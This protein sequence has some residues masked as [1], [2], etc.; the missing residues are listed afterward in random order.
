[1]DGPRKLGKTQKQDLRSWELQGNGSSRF[2]AGIK[3]LH[4]RATL[5]FICWVY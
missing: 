5:K 4:R 1:M 3:P 2:A